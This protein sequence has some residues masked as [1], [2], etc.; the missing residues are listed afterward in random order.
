ME[1]IFRLCLH[2][3]VTENSMNSFLG[4]VKVIIFVEFIGSV[5]FT[6]S[7]PT[8]CDPMDFSKPGLPI[9]HQLLKFA[10]TRVHWVGDAI[11]LFHPMSSPSLPAFNLSQHQG[12]FQW[13][14][15]LHQLAKVLDFWIYT[16][17]NMIN[18]IW[19]MY[20]VHVCLVTQ[21]C[22]TL[23]NP[24]ACIPPASSL[25]EVLQARIL[26][27]VAT[28]CSTGPSWPWDWSKV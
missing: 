28:F 18:N 9:H 16:I 25:H 7:Y 15:S 27:W 26:E 8:L 11:Q 22:L 6:Q 1:G 5:Q 23:C 14:S 20:V 24:R 17:I 10:H 4:F 2:Y 13:V 3:S 21:S 12:L 19:I